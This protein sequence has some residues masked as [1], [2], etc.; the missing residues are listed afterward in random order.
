MVQVAA[1]RYREGQLESA[2][3]ILGASL[4]MDPGNAEARY[5]LGL[6]QKSK[7]HDALQVWY[8]TIPPQ[9]ASR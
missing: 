6:L 9:R 3:A 8:P 1:D 7:Y 4:E 2:K 5:Y